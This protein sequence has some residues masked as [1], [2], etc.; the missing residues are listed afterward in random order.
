[1]L[2]FTFANVIIIKEKSRVS[3]YRIRLNVCAVFY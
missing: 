3:T 2:D 1:M